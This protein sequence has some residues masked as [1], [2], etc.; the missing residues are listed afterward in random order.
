[1]D[2]AIGAL[3]AIGSCFAAFER[4]KISIRKENAELQELLKEKTQKLE[5]AET[6]NLKLLKRISMLEFALESERQNAIVQSP[7]L[8]RSTS[9]SHTPHNARSPSVD[10]DNLISPDTLEAKLDG[11]NLTAALPSMSK[12]PP[13]NITE[14]INSISRLSSG[15]DSPRAQSIEDGCKTTLNSHLD[16]IRQL[17]LHPNGNF[18]I[19]AADDNAIKI[20]NLRSILKHPNRSDQ[21][22]VRVLRGQ[23]SRLVSLEVFNE[24]TS[25]TD[26][27]Q[28]I[29]CT[30]AANGLIQVWKCSVKDSGLYSVGPTLPLSTN[31]I[32]HT[33]AVWSLSALEQENLL[34]SAS[35]DSTVRAWQLPLESTGFEESEEM[36][37]ACFENFIPSVAHV[38][39]S[40]EG[41]G[42]PSNC[43][44][45]YT[46]GVAAQID[47]NTNQL[48]SY[49]H[50]RNLSPNLWESRS[51]DSI[52]KICSLPS[53]PVFLAVSDTGLTIGDCRASTMKRLPLNLDAPIINAVLDPID[54][55]RALVTTLDGRVV[56]Y[57]V[58]QHRILSDWKIND[59]GFASA[60]AWR[61]D[62]CAVG[63]EDATLKLFCDL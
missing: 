29:V 36:E 42:T 9:S 26:S 25:A 60:L 27:M 19:S 30:G 24:P 5:E 15:F 40:A 4:E 20:W 14:L 59:G 6:L 39:T 49:W 17:K 33:D 23:E 38:P 57:S 62:C 18:V 37:I 32:G 53:L 47:F 11:V 16:S 35:A 22:P 8:S 41:I 7:R 48:V 2:Q 63:F 3:D 56:M 50:V 28:G 43:I 55:S 21:E 51:A 13:L 44:A 46:S 54:G 45:G 31:L 61:G 58:A 10:S 12:L 52:H 34:L 1:M